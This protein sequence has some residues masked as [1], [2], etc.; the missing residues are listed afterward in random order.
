MDKVTQDETL[1][2]AHKIEQMIPYCVI[3]PET[4][5]DI[6]VILHYAQ[7]FHAAV[8]PWGSGLFMDLGYSLQRYDVCVDLSQMTSIISYNTENQ[9]ISVAAGV[10]LRNIQRYLSR[11]GRAL[12]FEI[13]HS[14]NATA[15]GLVAAGMYE[16]EQGLYGGLRAALQEIQLIDA[17]G[18]L[19]S[20]ATYKSILM[21]GLSINEMCIGS[22]GTLGIITTITLR[23]IPEPLHELYILIGFPT[24]TAIQYFIRHISKIAGGQFSMIFCCR[25][26]IFSAAAEVFGEDYSAEMD[27]A[28]VFCVIKMPERQDISN[29]EAHFGKDPQFTSSQNS[30][31]IFFEAQHTGASFILN[32][33][34]EAGNE[35]WSELAAFTKLPKSANTIALLHITVTS[36]DI[37]R[38]VD[39]A[40]DV[41]REYG[42]NCYWL[43]DGAAGNV[44]LLIFDPTADNTHESEKSEELR[45]YLLS[46][47]TYLSTR[48]HNVR[49]LWI[50]DR[51]K[52][53]I[54]LWKNASPWLDMLRTLKRQRDP[55][56]IL[57][58]GKLFREEKDPAK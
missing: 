17:S 46:L 19:Y 3:Y 9:C 34:A 4:E 12:P 33:G 23:T 43:A 38:L 20:T 27:E 7:E 49:V 14:L 2:I 29:E 32:I 11:I 57:N 18:I 25:E 41:C 30:A 36:T 54:A 52:N 50:R 58:P 39:G 55:Q 16:I 21:G 6:Q 28:E 5:S 10:P 22:L 53:A 44:W 51:W 56:N 47:H 13:T 1:R 35:I 45:G 26:G 24:L 48:W 15:G 31:R 40:Q 37:V 8:T 42:L